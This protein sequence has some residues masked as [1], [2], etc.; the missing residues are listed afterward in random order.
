MRLTMRR[1]NYTGLDGDINASIS[2]AY[3]IDVAILFSSNMEVKH[4]Q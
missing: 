3:V 2:K 1:E 4:L